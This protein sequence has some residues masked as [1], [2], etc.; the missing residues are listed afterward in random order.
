MP[1]QDVLAFLE[2]RRGLLDGV[3]FSGGEPTLQPA[4]LGA[5][6]AT[7]ALGFRVGLHTGGMMTERFASLLPWVDW[8]GFDVKAPFEAYSRITGVD[9]SGDR[10]LASL[11]L[12]LESKTPY[13]VRTTLHPALLS[14]AEMLELKDQLLVLGVTHY[15]VQHFRAQG[16]IPGRLAVVPETARLNLP[17][18]YGDGFRHFEIR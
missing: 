1:W 11:L 7:K 8:V 15:A 3:V 9:E 13:E 18:G 16:V 12:L 2:S 4:L 5:V 14:A 6:Q 17:Q 10:A